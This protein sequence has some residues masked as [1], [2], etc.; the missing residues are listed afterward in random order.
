MYDLSLLYSHSIPRVVLDGHKIITIEWCPFSVVVTMCCG[1]LLIMID[2][3]AHLV[4]SPGNIPRENFGLKSSDYVLSFHFL[5]LRPHLNHLE[6]NATSRG[7]KRPFHFDDGP[8]GVLPKTNSNGC[9]NSCV[10]FMTF[11]GDVTGNF[12]VR[13][14]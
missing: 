12:D 2:G 1:M 10:R 11:D 6:R 3:N 9:G 13:V 7:E 14:D 8:V 5:I 4:S